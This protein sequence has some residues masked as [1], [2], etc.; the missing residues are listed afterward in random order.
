M[1]CQEFVELEA[2]SHRYSER[3]TQTQDATLDATQERRT[4]KAAGFRAGEAR[5]AFILMLHLQ[6]C[7]V[8]RG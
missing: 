8:C 3:R 2:S 1:P 6:N 4:G 5:L 7:D